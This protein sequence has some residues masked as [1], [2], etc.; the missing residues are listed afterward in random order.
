[1]GVVDRKRHGHKS[2]NKKNSL[3]LPRW[4]YHLILHFFPSDQRSEIKKHLYPM[5]RL[6]PESLFQS[7]TNIL[8]HAISFK[9]CHHVMS[10]STGGRLHFLIYLSG[11]SLPSR[12][13]LVQSQQWKQQ[14]NM[15]NIFRV[16]KKETRMTSMALFWRH[17]CKLWIDFTRYFD[18]SIVTLNMLM[19]VGI[20][21]VY[22]GRSGI[23]MVY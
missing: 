10:S 9:S 14:N 18:V 15:W 17:Y 22:F 13:L 12:H 4:H 2:T 11:F 3:R 23:D 5:Y 8:N 20:Y 16:N 6:P 21:L 7:L 19:P 1:M